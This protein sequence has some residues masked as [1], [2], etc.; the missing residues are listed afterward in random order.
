MKKQNI[1]RC[2][3]N[4]NYYV[5]LFW[6]PICACLSLF[7]FFYLAW[8]S[9]FNWKSVFFIMWCFIIFFSF[10][11][12]IRFKWSCESCISFSWILM[13][14][15][16]PLCNYSNFP[17]PYCF[18]FLWFFEASICQFIGKNYIKICNYHQWI[19]Y[20][21]VGRTNIHTTINSWK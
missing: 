1:S 11:A 8:H 20:R 19:N 16:S 5:I 18:Y 6:W 7:R 14:W 13:A 15:D 17:F 4:T 12:L 10:G 9:C 21:I 2:W 3:Y